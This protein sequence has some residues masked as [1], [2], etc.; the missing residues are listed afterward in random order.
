MIKLLPLNLLQINAVPSF[1]QKKSDT[2]IQENSLERSPKTD[3]FE[4]VKPAKL[5]KVTAKDMTTPAQL[6]KDYNLV[7]KENILGDEINCL[8]QP[9]INSKGEK[10]F[11]DKQI[12]IITLA[13][14]KISFYKATAKKLEKDG[15]EAIEPA[16]KQLKKIF[17]GEKN[18]ENI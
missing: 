3:T 16:I 15:N 1:G 13:A 2:G 18:L 7:V 14:K 4:A 17:G 12:K 6:L 10:I 8:L 11:T 5:K 9:K